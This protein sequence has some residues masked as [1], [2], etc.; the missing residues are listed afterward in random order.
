MKINIFTSS[1]PYGTKETFI[2]TEIEYL[3]TK[4]EKISIYPFHY[5]GTSKKCIRKVPNNVSVNKP[6]I[7]KNLVKRLFLLIKN[8]F[9]ARN[10]SLFIK[11]FFYHKVFLSRN[12]FYLW[13]LNLTNFVILSGSQQLKK[14]SKEKDSIFYFYWGFGWVYSS[15][16]LKKNNMRFLRLHGSDIFLERSDNYLPLRKNIFSKIDYFLPISK[17]IS[18]YLYTRYGI[19]KKRI[20]LSYLGSSF[21]DINPTPSSK[22]FRIV[23]TSNLIQLKRVN[24]IIDILKDLNINIEWVHF[25]DGVQRNDI[26]NYANDNLPKNIKFIFKGHVNN[27]DLLKYYSKNYVDIFI[28]TSEHEG[29]PFSIIEAMS[30]GIPCIA[31]DAGA[32]NEIV[33]DSNGL[34]L[35]LDFELSIVQEEI[36]N[37]RKE[38]WMN[39]R[40]GAYIT[41]NN[42][43]NSKKNHSLLYQNFKNGFI[44]C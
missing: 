5:G 28:N 9:L 30:F 6:V 27:T 16:L 29:L 20:F 32:T 40:N 31:T 24:L 33:N 12:K 14:L 2:K 34:L 10:I 1:Y 22:A 39:K 17:K 8:F 43:F 26:I 35:P 36:K 23:S 42:I 19:P 18:R 21:T 44:K 41:W 37:C 38:N 4:F 7:P 11:E 13:F 3:A 25:G 15:I